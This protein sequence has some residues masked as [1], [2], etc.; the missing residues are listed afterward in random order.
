MAY[1]VYTENG[2][3]PYKMIDLLEPLSMRTP[4]LEYKAGYGRTIVTGYARID[5]EVGI[6]AN[7]KNSLKISLVKCSL[8]A[9]FG[10]CG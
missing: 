10:L 1:E 2:A 6:V 8:E 3:K 7:N 5:D 9:L 4:L